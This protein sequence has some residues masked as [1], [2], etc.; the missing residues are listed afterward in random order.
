MQQGVQPI[1]QEPPILRELPDPASRRIVRLFNSETIDVAEPQPAI[2]A[3]ATGTAANWAFARTSAGKSGWIERRF[4]GQA[5]APAPVPLSEPVFVKECVRAEIVYNAGGEGE[6]FPVDADYLIAWALIASNIKD[7]PADPANGGAGGPFALTDAEWKEYL[8]EVPPDGEAADRNIPLMHV[9]PAAYLSRKRMQALS[10]KLTD[11]ALHDGPYVPTYLNVFHA[12][13]LGVDAAAEVQ[14]L[15]TAK[16]GATTI[17]KVLA[18]TVPDPAARDALT[19][20]HERF[21]KDGANPQTVDGF[22]AKTSRLL[23]DRF[24]RAFKLIKELAPESIPPKA[25][26]GAMGSW[27]EAA[28]K[29]LKVW[30]TSG[31]TQKSGE[32]KQ[33]VLD[34]FKATDLETDKVLSWCGAF[35]AHCLKMAGDPAAA[36]IIKGASWAA[37]WK[38]WGDTK[39]FLRTG[40]D[41]D[42]IPKGAVV[43]L[44][45]LV[46]KASGHVGFFH[47][48]K[49]GNKIV[50]LGGN[51][52]GKV[53]LRAF[54][55]S[56]LVAIR[57]LAAAP[58]TTTPPDDTPVTS[59]SA[60]G[61]SA[62]TGGGVTPPVAGATNQDVLTLARTLYG[63]ARGEFDKQGKGDMPVEAVANVIVNRAARKFGGRS[64]V[65]GVCRHPWQFSCW[66]GNDTNRAKI[67]NLVKGSNA[68]FDRCLNVAA[69]VIKGEIPDHTGGALHYHATSIAKPD[70]VRNSPNA[71]VSL[72]I[73]G[74]IFYTGIK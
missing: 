8:A 69:R 17:D 53:C 73:G 48:L 29:E 9:Y 59:G 33:R 1:G 20:R 67:M 57:W 62:G 27:L 55:R 58:K 13:L 4:L 70:W 15:L 60:S 41:V 40:D 3:G 5:Q 42:G 56:K 49:E 12:G 25:D 45:P 19:K 37:N 74:H 52:S 51:Q 72:K 34:Y 30:E 71:R 43:L 39:L 10:E 18:K 26:I 68:V 11:P 24:T 16:A 35:V 54:P 14:K 32:G 28:E 31:L 66:N 64:T 22:R 21:L 46:P 50:L 6:S 65:Q 61:G 36:S 63:E 7:L 44:E 2:P 38:G 23:N 47:S